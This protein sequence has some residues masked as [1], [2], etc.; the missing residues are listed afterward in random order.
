MM[1]IGCRIFSYNQVQWLMPQVFFVSVKDFVTF[2]GFVL[3]V[4]TI[5][6]VPQYIQKLLH[7]EPK[8]KEQCY[9]E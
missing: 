7:F 6:Y 5:F 3:C 2:L 4:L 1:Y 8:G 9:L